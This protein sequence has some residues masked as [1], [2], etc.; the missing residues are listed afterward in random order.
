MR[1]KYIF[2]YIISIFF[3]GHSFAQSTMQ[4]D[5]SVG[6]K[7]FKFA[8]PKSKWV[9]LLKKS[10]ISYE[11]TYEY[12]GTCCKTAFGYNISKINLSFNKKGLNRIVLSLSEN[13][14]ADG[15][16]MLYNNIVSAFGNPTGKDISTDNSGNMNF[17]WQGKLCTLTMFNVY[18]GVTEGGWEIKLF[19]D[20][21]SNLITP[22]KDY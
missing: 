22:S 10:D 2:G 3:I 13:Q 14:Q 1:I 21:E 7:E 5:L 18:K 15:Q 11:D 4:L 12:T 9:G 6:F 16:R 20:L 19:F 17:Q 8:D